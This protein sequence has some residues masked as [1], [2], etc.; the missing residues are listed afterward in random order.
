MVK[1]DFI[2]IFLSI[3]GMQQLLVSHWSSDD[4]HSIIRYLPAFILL[5]VTCFTWIR[6]LSLVITVIRQFPFSFAR[7]LVLPISRSDNTKKHIW[8]LLKIKRTFSANWQLNSSKYSCTFIHYFY[9]VS[10]H[11]AHSTPVVTIANYF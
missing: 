4:T 11:C 10:N 9:I 7:K 2:F 3:A 6:S 1:K 5:S 8:K